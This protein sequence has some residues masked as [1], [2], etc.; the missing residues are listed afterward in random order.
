[1]VQECAYEGRKT[2]K[3]CGFWMTPDTLGAFKGLQIL[4]GD[5]RRS[6]CVECKAGEKHLQAACPQKG[7]KRPQE[8]V[9]GQLQK[10]NEHDPDAACVGDRQG[11]D[12]G[13]GEVGIVRAVLPQKETVIRTRPPVEMQS[14]DAALNY[15]RNKAPPRA[16]NQ[17]PA[18]CIHKGNLLATADWG[19]WGG[20]GLESP[21]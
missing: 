2:G 16:A 20:Q 7:D 15:D 4:P 13:E 12:Q 21:N 6:L 3:E 9:P 14:E 17:D 18:A 1:M 5:K 10:A 19:L 8:N 11:P